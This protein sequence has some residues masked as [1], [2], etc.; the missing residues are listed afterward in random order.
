M[1]DEGKQNTEFRSQKNR[2]NKS[3]SP[4]LHSEFCILSPVSCSSS[5]IPPPS[6]LLS[7]GTR[8]SSLAQRPKSISLQ[9]SEQK[10]R[11]GLSCHSAGLLQFGH[12][13][14]KIKNQKCK[15]EDEKLALRLPF[16]IFDFAFC[17]LQAAASDSGRLIR[18]FRLTKSMIPSRRMAFKRTVTLSR[19]EPTM[20]AISRCGS[21]M[22]MRTPLVSL[23]P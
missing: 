8:Y 18:I 17:I 12:F 23:M 21:G 19:V 5:L 7:A 4:P 10:G 3:G 16:C 9:R 6:S 14:R 13:I 22:S 15:M 1:R 11:C 2:K 20:E